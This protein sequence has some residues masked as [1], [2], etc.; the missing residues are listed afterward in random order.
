[1][2]EPIVKKI[3]ERNTDPAGLVL[4]VH[5]TNE[6]EDR[7]FIREVAQVLDDGTILLL[8]KPRLGIARFSFSIIESAL[9][10]GHA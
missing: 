8:C 9:A 3:M 4:D 7:L 2:A 1:M 5:G 10:L 6:M